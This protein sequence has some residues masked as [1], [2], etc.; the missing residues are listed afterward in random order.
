MSWPDYRN[1][2]FL[3]ASYY[4]I[5]SFPRKIIESFVTDFSM[6]LF[7]FTVFQIFRSTSHQNNRFLKEAVLDKKMYLQILHASSGNQTSKNT[8]DIQI[9]SNRMNITTNSKV[10]FRKKIWW[11]IWKKKSIMLWAFSK[12]MKTP[13]LRTRKIR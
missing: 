7:R 2:E 12:L 8:L 9:S 11:T 1:T 6:K 10:K 4:G 3:E 13:S 5:V